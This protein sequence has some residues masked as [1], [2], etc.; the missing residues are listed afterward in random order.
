MTLPR[1]TC[2]R[3]AAGDQ[4]HGGGLRKTPSG[5][6]TTRGQARLVA[7]SDPR[8]AEQVGVNEVSYSD[9]DDE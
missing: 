6:Q 3:L 4:N 2:R 1:Q 9:D 5:D 8:L 7:G